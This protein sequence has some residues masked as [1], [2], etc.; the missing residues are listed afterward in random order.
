MVKLQFWVYNLWDVNLKFREKYHN[1]RSKITVYTMQ[2][3]RYKLAILRKMSELR[4]KSQNCVITSS[5]LYFTY[6]FLILWQKQ[7]CNVFRILREKKLKLQ[8]VKLPWRAIMRRKISKLQDVNLQ[9]QEKNNSE[10]PRNSGISDILKKSQLL[11]NQTK[12]QKCSRQIQHTHLNLHCLPYLCQFISNFQL[13]V[14]TAQL[15][16]TCNLQK[17]NITIC[18]KKITS[19]Y[20]RNTL[21]DLQPPPHTFRHF[22]VQQIINAVLLNNSYKIQTS[23][24]MHTG[25]P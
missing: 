5:F 10:S 1:Q 25:M 7:H 21:A 6:L 12:H 22:T 13:V 11:I 3:T 14:M 2:V 8:Y 17:L 19:V 9:L 23:H 24:M 16:K 4:E 20:I 18:E 15:Q